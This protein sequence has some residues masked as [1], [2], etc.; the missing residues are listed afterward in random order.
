VKKLIILA[1]LFS[2]ATITQ[3]AS[4]DCAKAATII[5][6][7]IC[8]DAALSRLDGELGEIYALLRSQL[9][10]EEAKKLKRDQVKWIQERNK[11]CRSGSTSCLSA[12]IGT[13]IYTLRERSISQDTYN[14]T[15][16]DESAKSALAL[17]RRQSE[18]DEH[19]RQ[20]AQGSDPIVWA[21]APVPAAS[22]PAP[23]S[24]DDV[25]GRLWVLTRK[26]IAAQQNTRPNK[27]VYTPPKLREKGEFEKTAEYQ[28]FVDDQESKH[29]LAYNTRLAEYERELAAHEARLS[30]L[31]ENRSAIYAR[32]AAQLIPAW[33]GEMEE[34]VK[35]NADEE[36]YVVSVVS[37]R[38]PDY[39]IT[40]VLPVPIEEAKAKNDRIR[41]AP[42]KIVFST[43]NDELKAK[44]IVVSLDAEDFFGSA[45]SVTTLALTEKAAKERE[46]SVAAAAEAA[47][48]KRRKKEEK[49]REEAARIAVLEAKKRAAA[50]KEARMDAE[51]LAAIEANAKAK[52]DAE[53]RKNAARLAALESE[54]KANEEAETRATIKSKEEQL[55]Q[56]LKK[57]TKRKSVKVGDKVS[58]IFEPDI[59][60]GQ[61]TCW[62]LTHFVAGNPLTLERQGV[63]EMVYHGTQIDRIRVKGNGS[64]GVV[65]LPGVLRGGEWTQKFMRNT[66]HEFDTLIKIL[67]SSSELKIDHG[68]LAGNYV[69]Q[70]LDN[71]GFATAYSIAQRLCN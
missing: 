40:G 36:H 44:V 1:L 52:K 62:V 19:I 70:T 42:T 35:Y 57:A 4:F 49:R 22:A 3:S 20:F 69:I 54:K 63:S 26:E 37:R 68:D 34:T 11:A 18:Y 8:S 67:T 25:N 51:R 60:G 7:S 66:H 48:E 21:E 59:F 45:A 24:L 61:S 33:L 29:Q 23:D 41:L 9:S 28:A 31:E 56:E 47:E 30:E 58:L 64:P 15:K 55:F 12:S 2:L 13:R 39:Q 46:K 6:K 14:L 16:T 38:Y 50:E 71:R 17:Q 32:H 43:A 5:E 65:T 53:A 10:G 27:P